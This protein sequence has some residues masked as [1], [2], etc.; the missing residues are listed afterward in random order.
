MNKLL[1]I[2]HNRKIISVG[3]VDF[4]PSACTDLAGATNGRASEVLA[5]GFS[6]RAQARGWLDG[7]DKGH[8]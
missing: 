4:S 7:L 2:E 5:R 1:L 3:N 6:T 8:E